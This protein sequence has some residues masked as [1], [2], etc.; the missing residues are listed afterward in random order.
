MLI[1]SIF[2]ALTNY[3]NPFYITDKNSIIR[4]DQLIGRIKR[5]QSIILANETARIGIIS[6]EILTSN[7][8]V[9]YLAALFSGIDVVFLNKNASLEETISVATRT[10]C[11]LL[12]ADATI[13][14]K[15]VKNKDLSYPFVNIVNINTYTCKHVAKFSPFV[16]PNITLSSLVLR[17]YLQELDELYYISDSEIE[18]I[19]FKELSIVDFNS[20]PIKQ[21]SNVFAFNVHPHVMH[22]AILNSILAGAVLKLRTVTTKDSVVFID[23]F[24]LLELA[25]EHDINLMPVIDETMWN[26]AKLWFNNYLAKTRLKKAFKDRTVIAFNTEQIWELI[27][28][29]K[30]NRLTKKGYR[31]NQTRRVL[32]DIWSINSK[33]AVELT[34]RFNLPIV[35]ANY[36]RYEAFNVLFVKPDF[37]LGIENIE[38]FYF[39]L[40][41]FQELFNSTYQ[42][43]INSID[44]PVI[45]DHAVLMP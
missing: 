7:V 2:Q 36:V 44:R 42:T 14:N 21:N 31:P 15:I 33:L 11:N 5:V 37:N 26:E 18:T 19:H 29:L 28:Y 3:E 27:K 41:Q 6:S 17:D 23:G 38:E 30:V 4:R 32:H 25:I 40:R 1:R 16:K 8:V 35:S 45:I 13:I 39:K 34:A 20:V 10:S 22:F 9:T 12:F 43:T 24:D